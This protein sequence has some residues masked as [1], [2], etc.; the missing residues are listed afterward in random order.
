MAKHLIQMEVTWLFRLN[1]AQSR[2]VLAALGGRL[3]PDQIE[4]AKELGDELTLLRAQWA[5][6]FANEMD[7]HAE[8]VQS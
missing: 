2:L 8:K 5:D 6:Q 3:R 1:G 4:E 7:K